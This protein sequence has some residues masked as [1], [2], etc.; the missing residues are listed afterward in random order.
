MRTVI[1]ADSFV[2]IPAKEHYAE[3]VTEARV[4][5]EDLLDGNIDIEFTIGTRWGD[6]CSVSFLDEESIA[7]KN[8]NDFVNR[9]VAIKEEL[10][11]K[12]A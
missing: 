5:V 7:I 8:F 11:R 2:V 10:G 9:L 1:I 3:D 4:I 12:L 6:H